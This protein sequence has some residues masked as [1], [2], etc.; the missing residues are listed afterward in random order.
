VALRPLD[1]EIGEAIEV[2]KTVRNGAQGNWTNLRTACWRK[3]K[4]SPLLRAA[5]ATD[6]PA[7]LTDM[8]WLLQP[9]GLLR[10]CARFVPW[11]NMP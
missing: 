6:E 10:K 7:F 11:I 9:Q 5:A 8:H 3:R 4:R 2:G 1:D